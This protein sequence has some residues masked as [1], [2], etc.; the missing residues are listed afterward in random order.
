MKNHLILIFYFA[1]SIIAYG[2]EKVTEVPAH[3]PVMVKEGDKYFLFTTGLGISVWSSDD[4]NSWQRE[5]PVFTE[6]PA[7]AKS[8]APDFKNH[9]WAPDVILHE[10]TYYLYYSVSSFAKNTSAIGVA[11]NKTL[12]SSSPE[13]KWEDHGIVIQ[14]VPGRDL[15]N[16]IDPHIIKDDN[17]TAWMSFG[18]FWNGLKLVKL[19]DDLLSVEIGP[20]DWFTIARRE[21]TFTLDDRDP[22]DGAVEA[23]FIFRKNGEYYLFVSFDLCCRGDKST[24]KIVVGRS[25]TVQG[26]YV[27]RE[28]T[29][30]FEG[31]GTLVVEGNKDWYGV[32]HNSTYTFDGKD[33]LLFHGYEAANE[34]RPKLL[35]RAI[36]WDEDGWPTVKL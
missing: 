16:A 8:V 25:D 32:G 35:I 29:S 3:D 7:W 21:R 6:A 14:S 19:A 12:D 17:G 31:G 15:W 24:Y 36:E 30:M 33:F 9:I 26:P 18:S 23:P 5:K 20:E 28:G 1:F 4:M 22:G 27:D 2:Q 11:T 34:A 10:N 13:Y